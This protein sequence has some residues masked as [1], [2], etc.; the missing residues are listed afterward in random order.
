MQPMAGRSG[1]TYKDLLVYDDD[2]RREL[3]DGELFVMPSPRLDHQEIVGRLHLLLAPLVRSNQLGRLYLGPSD[4]VFDPSNVC[5]PDLVFVTSKRLEILTPANIQ[6]PPDLV[7]EV[8]S[9]ARHD[10]VRKRAIYERYRV[11]EYWIVDPTSDWVEVYRLTDAGRYGKPLI[12]QPGE[13]L[14]SPV[15][16]GLALNVSELFARGS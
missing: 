16:P 13:T 9:D 14:S 12:L 3:I 7:I 10:R 4:V 8:L 2:L 15:L 1:L 5:I 6:G 11:A